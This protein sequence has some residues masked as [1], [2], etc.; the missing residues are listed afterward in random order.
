[1]EQGVLLE[2]LMARQPCG[3][4]TSV[5]MGLVQMTLEASEQGSRGIA[6]PGPREGVG[7]WVQR[8]YSKDRQPAVR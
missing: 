7:I 8:E 3:Q 1:M 2:L 5:W 4:S 6:M